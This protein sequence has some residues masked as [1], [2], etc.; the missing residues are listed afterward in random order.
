MNGMPRPHE[1]GSTLIEILVT[2]VILTFGLLGLVGVSSRAHMTEL[3]SY[4]RVQALQLLQDMVNRLNA[5][6]KVASCY[7]NA[8]GGV[9]LGTGADSVPTCALGTAPQ[10]TQADADLAAWDEQLKGSAVKDDQ[11]EKLG[12]MIGAVGCIT[13]EPAPANTYL[14]AVAWQGMTQ[15]AAPTV[16]GVDGGSPTVFPCGSG[17]F[18]N[19]KQHRVV[20]AKVQ[21][22]TLVSEPSVTP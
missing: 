11:D 15:T 21:I 19:D 9:T 1:R 5:N 20:T 3:E 7:A 13:Q 4:Q 17:Q 16:G 18:G 10:R 2:L 12:A 22:G 6:R 8:G 14:I